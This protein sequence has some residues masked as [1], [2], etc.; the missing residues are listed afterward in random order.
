MRQFIS[1]PTSNPVELRKLVVLYLWGV[2]DGRRVIGFYQ[3]IAGIYVASGNRT[4][5]DEL[6]ALAQKNR[7]SIYIKNGDFP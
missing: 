7:L 3:I 2:V 1:P 4:F 6:E 5:I